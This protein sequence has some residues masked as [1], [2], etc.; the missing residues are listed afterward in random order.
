MQR[1]YPSPLQ[2]V[3]ELITQQE[4]WKRHVWQCLLEGW[5]ASFFTVKKKSMEEVATDYGQGKVGGEKSSV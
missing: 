4:R 5:L 2:L 1:P 3:G